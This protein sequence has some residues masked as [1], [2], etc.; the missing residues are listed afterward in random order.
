MPGSVTGSNDKAEGGFEH[1]AGV[2]GWGWH[3]FFLL[4]RNR[5]VTRTTIKIHVRSILCTYVC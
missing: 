2:G 3:V 1:M 4:F 5:K